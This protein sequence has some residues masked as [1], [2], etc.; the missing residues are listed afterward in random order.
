[1]DWSLV[2]FVVV[3]L[4]F[5]WR[6][7]RSGFLRSLGRVCAVIAG[8]AAA[9]LLGGPLAPSIGAAFGLNGIL[10]FGAASLAMFVL[11]GLF[12]SLI[13]MLLR[14]FAFPG[15]EVSVPSAIGGGLIGALVGVLIAFAIVWC[16]SFVRGMT[17]AQAFD[18]PSHANSSAVETLANRLAGRAVSAA[19]NAASNKTEV[20]HLSG[21]LMT[22]PAEVMQRS[23][24]LTN[25]REFKS[26]IQDPR[27]R[28]ILDSGKPELVRQLPAFRALAA[29]PD[30]LALADLAGYTD[31]GDVEARLAEQFTDIWG[32]AQRVQNNPRVQAIINDP[33]FQA[34]LKS[35][36]SVSLMTDS[37][38]LELA[39]IIFADES[40][41]GVA[42]RVDTPAADGP[43]AAPA[44]IYQWTD[45]TGRVHFSDQKPED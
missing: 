28:R 36:N 40:V 35:G 23:Q 44:E 16:Y 31:G 42:E 39:D 1:M 13:F 30:M 33:D 29:N 19:M 7:F 32:R 11:A 8:Y 24:R 22:A 17:S 9:I 10:A 18:T 37:Q 2:I 12:V 43:A 38:L 41:A 15:D 6:G 4:L 45:S 34:K 26:L 21:V 14:R 27:N 25:S 20:A 5:A 3:T